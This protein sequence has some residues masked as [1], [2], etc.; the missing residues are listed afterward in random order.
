VTPRRWV[1]RNRR[2]L[3]AGWLVL[4]LALV[5]AV[6][7]ADSDGSAASNEAAGRAD[8]ARLESKLTLPGSARAS[9]VEPAGDHAA[10]AGPW[11][12]PAI[13]NLVDLHQWW[14]V[15]G[16]PRSVLAYIRAHPPRGSSLN[17]SSGSSGDSTN[18]AGLGFGWPADLRVLASREL[19]VA[20]V[21]LPG[22]VTGLRVDAQEVWLTPRPA[23]EQIP[24]DAARLRVTVSR[25][26]RQLRGPLV[27][28]TAKTLRVVT[29]L[30]NWLPVVQ[31]GAEHCP[32]DRGTV[33]RLRFYRPRGRQSVADARIQ[34]GDC[35]EVALSL[36]G[37]AQPPLASWPIP[38]H[39]HL[40]LIKLLE[41]ELGVRFT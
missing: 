15:T 3:V 19:L 16:S 39:P 14:L 10:L 36:G 8:A 13:G 34:N 38:G 7:L 28:T 20:A 31:P 40:G 30:L 17:E 32:A 9:S 37:E 21:Q 23:A 5:S 2:V 11:S 33:V 12:F 4:A 27:Y 29:G 41:H 26:P 35:D 24:S 1:R 25:G 18:F 6:A 22:G